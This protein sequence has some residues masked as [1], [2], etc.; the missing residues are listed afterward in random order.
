[1]SAEADSTRT[2]EAEAPEEAP[3]SPELEIV[4][5]RLGPAEFGIPIQHVREVLRV[6]PI[7]PVPFTP[8]PLRGL[9]S[10]RGSLLPVVDLGLRLLGTPAARPGRLAAVQAP[11][12]MEMIA[13]LVDAVTGLET[14][15]ETQLRSMP[16]ELEA[17]LPN[18]IAAGVVSLGPGRLVTLLRLPSVL[19]LEAPTHVEHE[20]SG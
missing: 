13:L 16:P 1:M 7:A 14:V 17:A 18:G 5:V 19:A 11:D 6:P 2:E 10:V 12:A 8:E 4:T 3:S 9:V 20:N 15:A